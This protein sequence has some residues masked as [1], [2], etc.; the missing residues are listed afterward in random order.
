MLTK[1]G[2]AAGTAMFVPPSQRNLLETMSGRLAGGNA[3]S[4]ALVVAAQTLNT[5]G[6]TANDILMIMQ[7]TQRRQEGARRHMADDNS[8]GNVLSSE[9]LK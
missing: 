1:Q 8:A 3:A 6:A 5:N 2:Q 4:Q 9:E 7:N